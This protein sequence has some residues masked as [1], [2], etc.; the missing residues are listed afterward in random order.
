MDKYILLYSNCILT[1]GTSNSTICDLHRNK[2]FQFPNTFLEFILNFK[3]SSYDNIVARLNDSQLESFH[4][5][6]SFLLS[7]ELAFF[8]S[9]PELFIDLEMTWD[10]P[11]Q[12]TNSILDVKEDYSYGNKFISEIGEIG[13]HTL[14]IRI[15][16]STGYEKIR[17]LLIA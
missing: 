11:F 3:K 12:V 7:N 2:L 10:E 14:Q 13:C 17:N 16:E 5:M 4:E 8:T 6:V 9:D 15:F 1:N